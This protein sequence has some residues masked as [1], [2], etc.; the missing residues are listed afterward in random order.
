MEND[1]DIVALVGC[2]AALTLSGIPFFGPV[3][4]ARVGYET[5]STSSTRPS[6]RWKAPRWTSCSP[7]PPRAC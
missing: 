3:G 5:A 1:P 7:A 4:A 2:S 6:L